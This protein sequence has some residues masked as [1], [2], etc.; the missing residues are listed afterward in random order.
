MTPSTSHVTQVALGGGVDIPQ[1][2]FGVF[3]VPPDETNEAVL[4]AL[5][6]GYRHIDTAAAYR[7]EAGVGQAIRESGVPR[8]EVFVTTKCFNTNH[9]YDEA[10]AALKRSLDR[11]EMSHVDLYLIH[12]PVPSED[13]YVETWQAFIDAQKAGLARAIGV[14]NFQ[15]A[16][17]RRVIDETGVTPSINQVELHP[18]FQQPGLRREH[19]DLGIVTEAWSP[20]AQGKVLEDPVITGIAEAHGKTPGQVVIRWHLQL[21]NVVIPKSVTPER[22][23]ENFDVDFSL[24]AEEMDAIDGLD[25][26]ERIGPDPDTFV[27][28]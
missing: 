11:L 13:R 27:R 18:Y 26:G 16:H 1:L 23:A 15:P 9:G 10:T 12:W 6:A 17:L 21:G 8:E 2:G 3:Q 22:I 5:Q 20:L 14:S 19:A 25:R 28:P 7:N 4:R 24:T